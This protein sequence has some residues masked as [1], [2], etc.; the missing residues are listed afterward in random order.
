[1]TRGLIYT[2]RMFV[3]NGL[4]EEA[5]SMYLGILKHYHELPAHSLQSLLLNYSGFLQKTQRFYEAEE[6]LNQVG[7]LGD[8]DEEDRLDRLLVP[9]YNFSY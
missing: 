3:N 9:D 7:K 5:E 4:P 1:M 6:Y 8:Y 2:C